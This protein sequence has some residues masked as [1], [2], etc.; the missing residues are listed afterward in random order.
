MMCFQLRAGMYTT[1]LVS[2]WLHDIS[3]LAMHFGFGRFVNT[4]D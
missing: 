3:K 2:T 1:G 4:C